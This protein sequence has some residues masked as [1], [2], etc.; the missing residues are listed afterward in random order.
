MNILFWNIQGKRLAR[1]LLAQAVS[2]HQ[3]DIVAIAEA[4]EQGPRWLIPALAAIGP[5]R[6]TQLE[7]RL[8]V[9]SLSP[10]SLRAMGE[11]PHTSI[12]SVRAAHGST[13]LLA[14][15]HLPSKLHR[16]ATDQET[17]TRGLSEHLREMEGK[18]GHSRTVLIGDL[19]ANPFEPSLAKVDG[20]HA[21]MSQAVA[22]RGSRTCYGKKY[23]F[24]YNPMWSR[25]GDLSPGPPGTWFDSE[26]RAI[27]YFWH[28]FDQC[29]LRPELLEHFPPTGF[30]VLDRIGDVQLANDDGIRGGD[31]PDHLPLVLKLNW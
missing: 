26:S 11:S 8:Q 27:S 14:L 7:S 16:D 22:R 5:F 9:F 15:A 13:L 12:C 2:L 31:Y 23:P 25:L 30:E 29:L 19:N 20:L 28:S 1:D 10:L 6:S 4:P 21:V 3:I 24:F 17:I 18:V